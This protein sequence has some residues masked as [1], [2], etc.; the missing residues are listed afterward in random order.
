[1]SQANAFK[2]Q[3]SATGHHTHQDFAGAGFRDRPGL[4][5]ERASECV[6][7][8]GS[9]LHDCYSFPIAEGK[10]DKMEGSI[11]RRAKTVC[12]GSYMFCLISRFF[13]A[14]E[15]LLDMS[16]CNTKI[17]IGKIL[18]TAIIPSSLLL[19]E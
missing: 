11:L 19:P 7:H 12:T 5:F 17:L 8:H 10:F 9:H 3:T 6:E 14:R 18:L 2:G 15:F 1:M 16:D 4:S 13:H